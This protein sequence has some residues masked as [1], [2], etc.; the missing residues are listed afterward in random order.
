MCWR[1]IVSIHQAFPLQ[2]A[3]PAGGTKLFGRSVTGSGFSE[4]NFDFF[5]EDFAVRD[6]RFMKLKSKPYFN[7][8][9]IVS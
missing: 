9:S 2:S 4:R 7:P 1:S 5:G 3:C 8:K 6:S